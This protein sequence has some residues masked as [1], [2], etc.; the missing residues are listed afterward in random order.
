M[1]RL[2]V[3]ITN[4]AEQIIKKEAKR[5]GTSMGTIVTLWALDRKR[6]QDAFKAIEMADR[7]EQQ[8]S[9]KK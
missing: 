8:N 9:S 1:Y 7:L 3:N 4:E 2:N 6:E 5:I